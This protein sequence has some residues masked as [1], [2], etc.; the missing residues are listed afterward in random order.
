MKKLTVDTRGRVSLGKWAEGVSSFRA[1]KTEDGNLVL[2][3]SLENFRFK[4]SRIGQ[5]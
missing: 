2:E 1:H 3:P 5:A 4:L